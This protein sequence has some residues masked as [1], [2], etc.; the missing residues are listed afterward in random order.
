[1]NIWDRVKNFANRI[2][3][4]LTG[5]R[6]RTAFDVLIQGLG[7]TISDPQA[8]LRIPA[9]WRAVHLIASSVAQIPL[10]LYRHGESRERIERSPYLSV[11]QYPSPGITQYTFRRTLTAHAVLVGNGFAWVRWKQA[12]PTQLVILDPVATTAEEQ[13]GKLLWKTQIGQQTLLIPD[14]EVLHIC[15]LSW[16]GLRGLSSIEQF[17]G[18]FHLAQA[19]LDHA[20]GF[21]RHGTMLSGWLKVPRPL[22]AEEQAELQKAFQ[23]LFSG[24]RQAWKVPVLGGGIEWQS[25][26]VD[27]EKA[28]LPELHLSTIRDIAAVFGLPPHKLGDPSRTSYASLEQ[29]NLDYLMFSLESWLASWEAELNAKL[30]PP[31]CY[32]EHNR[33]A[34]IRSVYS[35]RVNGYYR[36]IEMGVLSPNEVRR[37]ENLPARPQGD[38]YYVPANWVAEA[39]AQQ[40]PQGA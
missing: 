36:M 5:V 14:D 11:L 27:P 25:A 35:D 16:D 9:V 30:A 18:A 28:Q 7:D 20:R 3:A 23:Q 10:H 12:T 37:M 32:W 19:L 33:N 6:G 40:E 39:S 4:Q 29:E 34:L 8:A 24:V 31:N 26:T 2:Y 13:D 38:R 22:S 21:F 15:G 17:G 1:M